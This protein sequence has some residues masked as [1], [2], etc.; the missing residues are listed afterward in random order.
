MMVMKSIIMI[1]ARSKPKLAMRA[2]PH[3]PQRL[4]IG[5]LVDHHKV[6]PN[7]AIAVT[8]PIAG[9]GMITVAAGKGLVIGQ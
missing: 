5:F 7:V 9:E 2:K 8:N 1:K 3:Q 4:V 6:W